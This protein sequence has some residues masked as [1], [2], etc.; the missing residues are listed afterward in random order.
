M[1][2]AHYIHHCTEQDEY[3]APEMLFDEDFSY[4]ADMFSFGMVLLELISRKKVST[5]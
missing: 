5:T 1:L 3:M 2:C 4:P